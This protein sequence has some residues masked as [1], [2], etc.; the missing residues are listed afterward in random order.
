M[1]IK[2]HLNFIILLKEHSK[3]LIAKLMIVI[4]HSKEKLLIVFY[5]LSKDK[6]KIKKVERN[7][8]KYFLQIHIVKLLEKWVKLIIH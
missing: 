7:Y 6:E 4:V 3:Y 1:H 8:Y 2:H 5:L